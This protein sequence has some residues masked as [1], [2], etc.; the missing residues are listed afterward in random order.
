MMPAMTDVEPRLPLVAILRGL[1]PAD[2]PAVGAALFAAGLTIVEV[3]LNRPG[4]LAAIAALA[5]AAPPGALVGGGTV[6]DTAAVDA[7]RGAGGRLVVAPNCNPAVIA[8]AIAL[9]MLCAP[10]VGTASEAFTALGCGAQALKLFP[11]EVWQPRGLAALKT[12]LPEGTPLW[13]VGGITPQSLAGWIAAGATGFGL[14][15]A[16]Y[17][18]GDGAGRVG[19]RAREF[20]AAW[21]DAQCAPGREGSMV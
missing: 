21:R 18:P 16:L 5:A 4:A 1:A 11:A 19:A 3:P 17:R 8:H 20:V 14:G 2:A 10:G 13:P 7:V 12:V 6:L 9:G 15:S